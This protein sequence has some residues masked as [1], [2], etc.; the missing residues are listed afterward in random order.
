LEKL[1]R[2]ADSDELMVIRLQFEEGKWVGSGNVS[3]WNLFA[4]DRA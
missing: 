3:R 2:A 4:T 1:R